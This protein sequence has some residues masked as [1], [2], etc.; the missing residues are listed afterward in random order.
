[1]YKQN[2]IIYTKTVDITQEIVAKLLDHFK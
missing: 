2:K 1:M